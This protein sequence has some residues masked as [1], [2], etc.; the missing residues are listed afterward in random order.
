MA[1]S[2]TD[3]DEQVSLGRDRTRSPIPHRRNR[4]ANASL[5]SGRFRHDESGDDE[6][7]DEEVATD[8]FTSGSRGNIG[9]RLGSRRISALLSQT[10]GRV[11]ASNGAVMRVVNSSNVPSSAAV[12]NSGPSSSV[13]ELQSSSSDSAFRLFTSRVSALFGRF[14]YHSDDS[15]PS[16]SHSL[17]LHSEA[18]SSN[19]RPSSSRSTS[20]L[21]LVQGESPEIAN[22]PLLNLRPT[23]H[24]QIRDF[25]ARFLVEPRNVM[26]SGT[27]MAGRGIQLSNSSQN[28]LALVRS[29]SESSAKSSHGTVKRF[30]L[31]DFHERL[32]AAEQR[33]AYACEQVALLNRQLERLQIQYEH[34]CVHNQRAFR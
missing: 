16:S 14:L 31:D 20:Y 11:A 18:T 7:L 19:P 12:N 21:H 9:R 22:V 8:S 30:D 3:E 25:R 13:N 27:S 23:N 28:R 32:R 10:L 2:E 5:T 4:I 33:F 17:E 26:L 15:S 6:D 29:E 1:Q 34:A 24:L